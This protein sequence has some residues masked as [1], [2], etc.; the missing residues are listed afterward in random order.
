VTVEGDSRLADKYAPFDQEFVLNI[1]IDSVFKESEIRDLVVVFEMERGSSFNNY[2]AS[3]GSFPARKVSFI[4]TKEKYNILRVISPPLRANRDYAFAVQFTPKSTISALQEFNYMLEKGTS[5]SERTAFFND[6]INSMNAFN[7]MAIQVFRAGVANPATVFNTI[8]ANQTDYEALYAS[9]I[10]PEL[11]SLRNAFLD[12]DNVL[13]DIERYKTDVD[14]C[15]LCQLLSACNCKRDFVV[16]ELKLPMSKLLM[17]TCGLAPLRMGP[18][19]SP[20]DL[21]SIATS[22]TSLDSLVSGL[23]SA[24]PFYRSP[25]MLLANLRF[26][27]AYFE[28]IKELLLESTLT[29]AMPDAVRRRLIGWATIIIEKLERRQRIALVHLSNIERMV[30]TVVQTGLNPA[31]GT[32]SFFTYMQVTSVN[33]SV[34]SIKANAGNYFIPEIGLANMLSSRTVDG[35]TYFLRPYLGV[36]ISFIPINKDIRFKDI[37]TWRYSRRT[38]GWLFKGPTIG[39]HLSASIGV[40]RQSIATN[41][42]EISDLLKDMC[43]MTGFN[44]RFTRAFRVGFGATWYR[45]DNPN[46]LLKDDVKVMPYISVALDVD[47]VNWANSITDVLIK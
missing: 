17:V 3:L 44:W 37:R 35:P 4:K 47:V 16:E 25:K 38:L 18:M 11:A 2:N 26:N 21:T 29:S 33:S 14:N 15:S 7:A 39:H 22:Q 19:A 5:L 10:G 9:S 45:A 8:P 6:V 31:G 43:L 42:P 28:S 24:T 27:I 23:A 40:T 34:A 46:P 20:R 30:T 32:P 41:H 1:P 12:A 13:D 36:N